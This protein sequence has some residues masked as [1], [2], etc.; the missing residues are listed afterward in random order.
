[1]GERL[2]RFK[3]KQ[4]LRRLN[5]QGRDAVLGAIGRN[6][7]IDPKT[8]E[9]QAILDMDDEKFIASTQKTKEKRTWL[10]DKIAERWETIGEKIGRGDD[11]TQT[12]KMVAAKLLRT[13]EGRNELRYTHIAE[14]MAKTK[15]LEM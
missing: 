8:P 15:Q 14:A 5:K 12:E 3:M 13:R 11:L 2:A 7:R 10:E 1:M 9:E 4:K 6:T